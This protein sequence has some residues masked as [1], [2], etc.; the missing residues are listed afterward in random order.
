[1]AAIHSFLVG[2]SDRPEGKLDT[3]SYTRTGIDVDLVLYSVL[4]TGLRIC[5][6]FFLEVDPTLINMHLF[7]LTFSSRERKHE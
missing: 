5:I 6:G 3:A 2:E 7:R 1:M 4:C